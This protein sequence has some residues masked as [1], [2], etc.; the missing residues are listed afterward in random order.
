M[1]NLLKPLTKNPLILLGLTGAV[2]VIDTAIHRKLFGSG[3]RTLI[4]LNAEKNDIMKTV[5]SLEESGLLIEDVSKTFKN[6]A[7]EQ[8]GE[9]L[10]ILLGTLGAGLLGKKFTKNTRYNKP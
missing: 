7:K 1:K 10:E 2:S 6:K 3:V 4:I 9:F 8:K 5:K